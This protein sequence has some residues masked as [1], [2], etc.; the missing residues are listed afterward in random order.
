MAAIWVYQP[1]TKLISLASGNVRISE[2]RS[3]DA[4]VC[5]LL[6]WVAMITYTNTI[7]VPRRTSE[8]WL[9]LQHILVHS[10]EIPPFYLIILACEC[11]SPGL[12]IS[13]SSQPFYGL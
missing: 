12:Q 11:R 4:I 6:S 1:P 8:L 2:F 13:L 9:G 3:W 7:I 10:F 5:S